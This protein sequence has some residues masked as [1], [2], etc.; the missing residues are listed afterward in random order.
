MA[1][2]LAAASSGQPNLDLIRHNLLPWA[3]PWKTSAW[4]LHKKCSQQK[5]SPYVP[6]QKK[7]KHLS[8]DRRSG[9]SPL[10]MRQKGKSPSPNVDLQITGSLKTACVDKYAL[11]WA[12][13]LSNS[14]VFL[15]PVRAYWIADHKTSQNHAS[16]THSSTVSIFVGG[17]NAH[18]SR[19]RGTSY[20]P[21]TAVSGGGIYLMFSRYLNTWASSDN[22]SRVTD[23]AYTQTCNLFVGCVALQ[24]PP[25]FSDRRLQGE[26]SLLPVISFKSNL[27]GAKAG[28]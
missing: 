15:S 5:R 28:L 23:P 12:G 13:K 6:D 2:F 7:L 22:A 17:P 26:T 4:Q 16:Q 8:D 24:T 1:C 18:R 25:Y 21:R 10:W 3:E 9:S 27:G 14:T 11:W 20:D 19:N